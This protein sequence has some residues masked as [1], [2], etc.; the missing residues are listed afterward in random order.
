MTIH[1]AH[2][3]YAIDEMIQDSG[4][5]TVT[6]SKTEPP[7]LTGP[8][9]N[10]SESSR[11]SLRY[12]NYVGTWT[13]S[14]AIGGRA[15][16][17]LLVSVLTMAIGAQYGCRSSVWIAKWAWWTLGIASHALE[18]VIELAGFTVGRAVARFGN[19]FMRGYNL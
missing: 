11:V 3:R 4:Y 9:S 10:N 8:P 18:V 17:A 5:E 6:Y 19:G 2:E 14:R 13:S 12:R 15:V 16:C 1:N 7:T